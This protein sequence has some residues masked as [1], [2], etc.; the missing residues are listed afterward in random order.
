[1]VVDYV[2]GGKLETN[3]CGYS[4]TDD[5]T[6]VKRFRFSKRAKIGTQTFLV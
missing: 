2:V 1:M 5:E 3:K 6:I 4:L